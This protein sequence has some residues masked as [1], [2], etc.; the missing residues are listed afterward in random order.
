MDNLKLLKKWIILEEVSDKYNHFLLNIDEIKPYELEEWKY[1]IIKEGVKIIGNDNALNFYVFSLEEK[2]NKHIIAMPH[3]LKKLEP[4]FF[5]LYAD[6]K[7]NIPYG[8]EEF[9]YSNEDCAE[10]EFGKIILPKTIKKLYLWYPE[11]LNEIYIPEGLEEI[12]IA[13][14]HQLKELIIPGSLKRITKGSVHDMDNIEKVVFS[15][16]IT[17]IEENLFR[18]DK[19]NEIHIPNS[20]EQTKF[21]FCQE[22]NNNIIKIVVPERLKDS[23]FGCKY[24]EII[25]Y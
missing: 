8:L 13:H 20:I 10:V 21:Y 22:N 6:A 19:L 15:H 3:S 4:F 16:G 9:K 23:D 1:F 5:I 25:T 7:Y 12:F 24:K 11:E 2:N 18:C 14:C 17:H